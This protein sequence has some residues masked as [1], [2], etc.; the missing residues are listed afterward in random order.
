M[1]AENAA[2]LCG[3]ISP[4]WGQMPAPLCMLVLHPQQHSSI[5]L[6]VAINACQ[7]CVIAERASI[8]LCMPKLKALEFM[9][10]G[11]ATCPLVAAV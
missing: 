11:R 10:L 6:H 1:P 9:F 4:V 5:L 2:R 8:L 3:Q 7:R